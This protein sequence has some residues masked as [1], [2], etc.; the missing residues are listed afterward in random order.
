[1][2]KAARYFALFVQLLHPLLPRIR[3]VPVCVEYSNTSVSVANTVPGSWLQSDFLPVYRS[4]R[5]PPVFH[6]TLRWQVSND[7]RI[8]APECHS[9]ANT[10]R[11]LKC[12]NVID[13]VC[14]DAE[15]ELAEAG[16]FYFNRRNNNRTLR[17]RALKGFGL[18]RTVNPR[19]AVARIRIQMR[20][21]VITY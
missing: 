19:A 2:H 16:S 4:L 6:S 8:I 15:C 18:Q 17:R 10:Q 5:R 20:S 14:D 12:H 1:M 7:A 11:S 9:P 3:C 21:L 13:R